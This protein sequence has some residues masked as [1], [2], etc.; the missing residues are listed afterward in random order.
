MNQ[1][2]ARRVQAVVDNI[3]QVVVAHPDVIKMSLLG[4]LCQGHILLDDFPGVGKTLLA[5]TLAGSL[6]ANFKRIQ[7]TPDLLPTDIT[8]ASIY[9]PKAGDFKFI[10]T[11]LGEKGNDRED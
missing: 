11:N 6:Q 1:E 5:K 9:N 7:F 3:R 4:L 8:G 10:Q 2:F